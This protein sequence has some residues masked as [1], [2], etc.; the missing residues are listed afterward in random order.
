M[1]EQIGKEVHAFERQKMKEAK[2]FGLD[3]IE[4]WYLLQFYKY[5]QGLLHYVVL[6]R[7][8][9][10]KDTALDYFL[11]SMKITETVCNS[12]CRKTLNFMALIL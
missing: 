8:E 11:E 1:L 3:V 6:R 4:K 10:Y 12:T 5:L 2:R 9:N 7:R